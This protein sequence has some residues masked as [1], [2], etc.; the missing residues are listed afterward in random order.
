MTVF[1]AFPSMLVGVR[2]ELAPWFIFQDRTVMYLCSR[3]RHRGSSVILY[4]TYFRGYSVNENS[5]ASHDI[6]FRRI[7]TP[8]FYT[9]SSKDTS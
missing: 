2:I 8:R 5:F 4:N 7:L 3:Q 6:Q 9:N 1:V